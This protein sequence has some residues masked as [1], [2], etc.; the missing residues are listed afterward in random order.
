MHSKQDLILKALKIASWAIFIALCIEAGAIIFNFVFTLFKPIGARNIYQ[1][2]NLSDLY[3]KSF[4]HYVGVM[5][6]MVLLSVLKAYLF[7]LVVKIFM[8]LNFVTPFSVEIATLI[9]KISIEALSIGIV[10]FIARQYAKRLTQSGLD[11]NGVNEYWSD[12][13][14]FLMMAAILYIIAQIFKKGI[15][16][17]NENDLTI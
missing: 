11:V 6:F 15:A 13:V 14:T 9:E 7:F 16:I 4:T 12:A 2:L 3:E 1:G 8:K 5:S 10:S 17:Q